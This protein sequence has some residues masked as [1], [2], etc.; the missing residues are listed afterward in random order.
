[1]IRNAPQLLADFNS[2]AEKAQQYLDNAELELA[3]LD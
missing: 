3:T 2:K 1:M